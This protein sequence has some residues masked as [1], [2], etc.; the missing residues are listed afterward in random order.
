MV[1]LDW[2]SEADHGSS[3]KADDVP[4]G[5]KVGRKDIMVQKSFEVAGNAV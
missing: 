2:L 4:D 1:R 3:V 5:P